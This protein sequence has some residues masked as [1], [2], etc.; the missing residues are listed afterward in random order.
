MSRHRVLDEP[1]ATEPFDLDLYVL[2][3]GLYIDGEPTAGTDDLETAR[4]RTSHHR[5]RSP[6]WTGRPHDGLD[7]IC[8]AATTPSM[9][10]SWSR[11]SPATGREGHEGGL[12]APDS[13]GAAARYEGACT[14]VA[15]M[16]GVTKVDDYVDLYTWGLMG[17]MTH[18][19]IGLHRGLRRA[20]HR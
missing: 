6:S 13:L 19:V 9:T 20:A 15:T 11:T 3:N 17:P 16:L 8:Y 12:G 5:S 2:W 14:D 18:I 7:Y 1:T 4:S 10:A